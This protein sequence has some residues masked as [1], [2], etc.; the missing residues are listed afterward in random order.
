MACD[1]MTDLDDEGA[2]GA[3]DRPASLA[4]RLPA[5]ADGEL[6]MDSLPP[7]RAGRRP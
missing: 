1:P 7:Q 3:G 2:R 5:P 6:G 4:T